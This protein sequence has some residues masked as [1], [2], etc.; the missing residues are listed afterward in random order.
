MKESKRYREVVGP[1]EKSGHVG[2][3]LLDGM[4][5]KPKHLGY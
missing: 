5:K 2:G 4:T 1:H 3:K